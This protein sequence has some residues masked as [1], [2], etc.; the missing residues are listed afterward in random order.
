VWTMDGRENTID[1]YGILVREEN[2]WKEL[3][4]VPPGSH[5][6]PLPELDLP[7]EVRALCVQAVGKASFLNHVS[8][9]VEISP[10]ASQKK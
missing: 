8:G 5:S 6:V 7:P 9:P 1:H 2:Q 3:T 10:T 4:E